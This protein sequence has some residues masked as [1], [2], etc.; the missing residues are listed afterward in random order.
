M[1]SA[2]GGW[3]MPEK[4]AID[5]GTPVKQS[6]NYSMYPGG[7][8]IGEEEKKE[9]LDILEHKYLFRYYLPPGVPS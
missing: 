5:G 6:P 1:P 4:L 7:L 2:L 3:S 8:E 9:V